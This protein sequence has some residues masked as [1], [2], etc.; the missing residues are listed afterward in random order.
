MLFH[1]CSSNCHEIV[2]MLW[3]PRVSRVYGLCYILTVSGGLFF[4]VM[5]LYARMC[6]HMLLFCA[7]PCC[8]VISSASFP[9]E[10]SFRRS[11]RIRPAMEEDL[12]L[13]IS[14]GS[15]SPLFSTAVPNPLSRVH[16]STISWPF[17]L[18]DSFRGLGSPRFSSRLPSGVLGPQDSP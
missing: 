3:L 6:W 15:S 2:L 16:L 8:S 18:P 14:W 17:H 9:I 4:S 7:G 13:T 11:L 5:L 12:E 10:S 1:A